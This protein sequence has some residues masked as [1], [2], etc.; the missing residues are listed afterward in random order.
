VSLASTG[1][2]E[3]KLIDA[4]RPAPAPQPAVKQGEPLPVEGQL[5]SLGGAMQWFNTPPLSATS[6]RGKV[7]LVDF[8]TYSCI[9]CIRSLPYV[10][11]WADK[12]KD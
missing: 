12:Y 8:W 3:Q 5:P 4:A 1:G 10:R 7:V 11:G 2:I 6:L 9:N